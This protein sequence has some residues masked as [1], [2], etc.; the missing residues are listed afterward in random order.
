MDKI[1]QNI[2][3]VNG[4]YSHARAIKTHI[5]DLPAGLQHL[6]AEEFE[7]EVAAFRAK[8]EF[9][10]SEIK[11]VR[12]ELADLNEQ[13]SA[14][15]DSLTVALKGAGAKIA[16]QAMWIAGL[17]NEI[18]AWRGALAKAEQ[19]IRDARQELTKKA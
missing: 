12:D 11:R 14:Q 8:L 13:Q 3:P 17:E 1:Q 7:R 15:I 2:A 19:R 16:E 5:A 4:S 9:E 18:S 6:V 10:Y